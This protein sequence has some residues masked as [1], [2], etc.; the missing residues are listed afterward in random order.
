MQLMCDITWIHLETEYS[1]SENDK[2]L[3]NFYRGVLREYSFN[4]HIVTNDGIRELQYQCQATILEK[5]WP[6]ERFLFPCPQVHCLIHMEY[7]L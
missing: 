3:G 7:E 5:C 1:L 4:F 6:R 2:W